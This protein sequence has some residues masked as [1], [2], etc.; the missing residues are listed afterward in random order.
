MKYKKHL[1]PIVILLTLG[2]IAWHKILNQ[3]I[4]GEGG[5]YNYIHGFFFGTGFFPYSLFRHD[6]GARIIYDIVRVLFGDNVLPLQYIMLIGLLCLSVVF[7]A[8]VFEITKSKVVAF[9]SGILFTVNFSTVF[10]MI[11]IGNVQ[12]FAQRVLQLIPEGLSFFFFVRFIRTKNIFHAISSLFLYIVAVLTAHYAFFFT[13]LYFS[14][15][16]ALLFRYPRTSVH[17]AHVGFMLM[18]YVAIS[19]LIMQLSIKIGRGSVVQT[20]NLFT[21][22][23]RESPVIP[24]QVFR[25]LTILTV[26]DLIIRSSMRQWN[27]PYDQVIQRYFVPVFLSYLSMLF[28]VWKR[29][30]QWRAAIVMCLLF[31]PTVFI[32]NLFMRGDEVTKIY[33]SSRYLHVASIGFSLFW[34]IAASTFLVKSQ[35]SRLIV[36]LLLLLWTTY[37]IR[38]IWT[39]ID[40]EMYL[41]DAVKTSLQ[42]VK[43]LSST[44]SDDSIVV[45]PSVLGYY[46]TYFFDIFYGREQIKF[47]PYYSDWPNEMPRPFDPSKDFIIDYDYSAHEVRDRTNEYRDII[48]SR[49]ADAL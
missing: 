19:L 24:Y 23:S 32:L 7:Y 26:P 1:L 34:G 18:L 22:L 15:A 38:A 48:R 33:T 45:T 13:P 6:A 40:K 25:Q 10:E 4:M 21:F 47:T 12:F 44:L 20:V 11:A 37:N 8:V 14:Y 35:R 2:F 46:G 42:Y 36:S 29:Q 9:V 28:I 31:L 43:K 41:H 16:I 17:W 5:F 49:K 3:V 27:L 30:K 39:E